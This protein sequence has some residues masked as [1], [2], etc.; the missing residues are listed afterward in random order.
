MKIFLFISLIAAPV[1]AAP[2]GMAAHVVGPVQVEQGNKKAPLKLLQ[3]LEDGDVVR[4]GAGAQSIIVL[5]NGG[6][7]YKIG[8]SQS[9]TVKPTDV[10]GATK[11]AGLSGPSAEAV[12]LLGN[13]R[14]GAVM[15]RPGQTFERLTEQFPGW[16]NSANA[17]FTWLPL[18][19]AAT[20]TFTLFDAHDNVVWSAKSE[21]TSADY[22]GLPLL[23]KRAYLWRVSGFGASG[24][25]V[26]DTRCGLVTFLSNED[27]AALTVL[28]GD[29]QNQAKD[30]SLALLMLAETYRAYG[31]LGR[32]LETLEDERL[33]AEP[34]VADAR[35]DV[36]ASLSP[37]ARAL[38]P[39]K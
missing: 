27:G 16:M 3:R 13:A 30:D 12:K 9:A 4:C 21:T 25:P 34:G 36:I 19:G 17:R 31:V 33:R 8:A 26:P 6:G 14:V 28:A 22:N 32:T 15:A 2:I 20:Y 1:F 5:F 24:K 10:I 39:E 35:R 38:A 23:E 18:P 11:L 37:F 7:R 29:L